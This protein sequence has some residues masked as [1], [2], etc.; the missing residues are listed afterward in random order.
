LNLAVSKIDILAAIS[1]KKAS[2]IFRS[3]ASTNSSSDF[4]ISDLKLTRKQYYS[5]MSNLKRA[6]LVTRQKG[7]YL[8][9][10]FG[11]VIYNAQINL[12]AKIENA[13]NNYWKLKAIG[14]MEVS[15]REESDKIISALIDN[16]EIRSVLMNG[17]P[18]LSTQPVRKKTHDTEDTLLAA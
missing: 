16:Q 7:G 2:N 12:E 4:L 5:R 13:I 3:I 11:K 1:D 18:H 9:T 15:S 14:S 6:G 17:D 8:L 10:P